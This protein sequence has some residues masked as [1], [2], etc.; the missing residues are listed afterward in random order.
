MTPR[1]GAVLFLSKGFDFT[2]S[3]LL[4]ML[5]QST[6]KYVTTMGEISKH[7]QK[8]RNV[9][10]RSC[11]EPTADGEGLDDCFGPST[12]PSAAPNRERMPLLIVCL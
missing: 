2:C 6:V 12:H 10:E 9:F 7:D 5:L 4:A 8:G 1:G 3:L 11:F